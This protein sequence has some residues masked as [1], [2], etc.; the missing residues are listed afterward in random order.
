MTG[1][2][3]CA[4]IGTLGSHLNTLLLNSGKICHCRNTFLSNNDLGSLWCKNDP[5]AAMTSD[6]NSDLR[7]VA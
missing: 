5:G 6:H 7:D 1:G 4:G 3:C 2:H